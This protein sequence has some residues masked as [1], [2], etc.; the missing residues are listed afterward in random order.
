MDEFLSA[1]I[2][3]VKQASE[4]CRSV[5]AQLVSSDA[6]LKKDKSPVTVADFASQALICQTLNTRFPHVPI[7]G[8]EDAHSLREIENRGL[9]EKINSFLPGWQVDEILNSIDLGNGPPSEMFWTLDPIDGTKGFLRGE[10][11]AVALALIVNG[12]PELGVLGC[13][14][15]GNGGILAYAQRGH[16]AFRQGS[17]ISEKIFVSSNTASEAVRFLESV[18]SGHSD[19]GLQQKI[20]AGFGDFAEAVRYDSQVKY[21]VLAGGE[22]DVY[23]RM[24]NPEKPDYREKIWDHAAGVIIVEEAGGRV[25]DIS[26]KALDFSRGKKLTENRGVVVTNGLLHEKILSLIS[27]V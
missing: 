9:L 21:A 12:R 14:N 18:E 26:G 19:H 4:I 20:M 7:V 27:L 6:L 23:L 15:L 2:E 1:A 11:Y 16:G 24:P 10:Q 3:A 8:E 13:P 22:A 17:A 25:S 5:Q